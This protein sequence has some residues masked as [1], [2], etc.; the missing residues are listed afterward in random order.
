MHIFDG[1]IGLI[2]FAMDVVAIIDC[3][4]RN[5]DTSKKILW[6]FLII[7]LP[8]VGLILYFLVGRSK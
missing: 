1:I 7:V 2:I 6:I 5:M 3:I 8:V 4:K